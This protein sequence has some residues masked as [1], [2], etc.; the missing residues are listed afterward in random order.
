MGR[1]EGAYSKFPIVTRPRNCVNFLWPL[2]NP[3]SSDPPESSDLP[4]VVTSRAKP[5]FCQIVHRIPLIC[6]SIV[7]ML[8]H[9]KIY[10]RA[11]SQVVHDKAP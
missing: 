5:R 10:V 11:V 3:E 9:N 4:K 1:K 8:M 2:V 6:Q 7:K